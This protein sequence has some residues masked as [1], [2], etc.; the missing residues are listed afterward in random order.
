MSVFPRRRAFSTAVKLAAY[1]RCGGHCES[2]TAPLRPGGHHYDHAIAA[3]LGGSSE[4]DNCRVLCTT[5]HGRKTYRYDFKT[6]A[7]A[8]R[9]FAGHVDAATRSHRPMPGGR[10]DVRK[11]LMNG[12]VV[13]RR[14][15]LPFGS[16]HS[17]GTP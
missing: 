5:C 7:K 12:L 15:G 4:I 2:C 3:A 6:I 14:T 13:D 16:H 8:K 1:E 11:R 10:D 17:R 9:L